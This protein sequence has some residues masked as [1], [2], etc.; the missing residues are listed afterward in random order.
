[1]VDPRIVRREARGPDDG[2]RAQHGAVGY[3]TTVALGFHAADAHDASLAERA[4]G[5]ADERVSSP[6]GAAADASPE[7]GVEREA[8]HQRPQPGGHI[9]AQH[10]TRTVRA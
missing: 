2:A 10:A 9:A 7:P 8:V 6:A 3:R 5:D 4:L 1:R